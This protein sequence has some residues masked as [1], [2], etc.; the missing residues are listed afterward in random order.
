MPGILGLVEESHLRQ[1][2]VQRRLEIHLGDRIAHHDRLVDVEMEDQTLFWSGHGT[3]YG[4]LTLALGK[5]AE[6]GRKDRSKS[7]FSSLTQRIHI[8]KLIRAVTIASG[9]GRERML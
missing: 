5:S 6:D 8:F 2:V 4:D 9:N 1:D 3:K 7:G